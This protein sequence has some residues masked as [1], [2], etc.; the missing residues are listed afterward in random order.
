MQTRNGHLTYCS[1]IHAGE[2]WKEHFDK[3]KEHIPVITQRISP[4][5]A[6]GI[7]LRLSNVASLELR[8]QENLEEF[9][10]WLAENNC[11]VFTM[12]GFPFGGF[13]NTV[14]K[15][16][17]HAP[18]WLSPERVSY[19][20]RLAQILAAILPDGVDGGISTSPLTYKFWHQVA[21]GSRPADQHT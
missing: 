7:G 13:H 6:F 8:K 14:V 9:K 11:Y 2:S 3:L 1:N 16:K 5:E 18:D 21:A 4:L 17:V 10:R 20:I 12:N 15:D 19:T